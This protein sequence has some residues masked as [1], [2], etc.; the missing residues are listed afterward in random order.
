MK[1]T[2]TAHRIPH[3]AICL[4]LSAFCFL[5]LSAQQVQLKGVVTVQNSKTHTGKTQY[6]KNAEIEHVNVKNAKTKDVTGDDGKFTLNIQGVGANTQTQIAVTLHGAYS[7]Y[8]IVNE[9]ELRDITLGRLTP[10]SVFICKKGDLEQRQAEMVG[11]NMRKLEE[12]LEKDKNRLQKELNDLRAKSDYMNVRYSEIKDS[13]NVISKNI[14]NAFERIKEY[15]KSMTLENLDDRDENYVKAYGAFS[16]GELDSVSYYLRDDELDLKYQKIVQLQH[17]AKKE[18]ELAAILTE[19]AQQK[20]EYSENKLNELIKEWLLLARTYDMK[21]DYEK[22]MMYYEKVVYADTLNLDVFVEYAEYLYKIREFAKSEKYFQYCLAKY[23]ELAANNP[24]YLPDV[25]FTLNDLANLQ[26]DNKEFSVALQNFEEAL[27]MRKE[28]A[29]ENPK[30]YLKYVASTLHNLGNLHNNLNDHPEAFRHYE[31]SLKIREELAK[32]DPKAH[33]SNIAATLNNLAVLH[34]DRNELEAGMKKHQE[35]LEIRRALA[36]ENPK[37]YL[38]AVAASLNNLA[39]LHRKKGEFHEAL[40]KYEEALKI[41]KELAVENPKAYILEVSQ[42]LNNLAILHYSNKEYPAALQAFEESLEIRRALAAENPKAYLSSV[43]ATLN[44]MAILHFAIFEYSTAV[45]KYEESLII[46]EKLA[47]DNPK[48]FLPLVIA[49][50]TDVARCYLFTKK[51]TQ[52]E[53]FANKALELDS[54]FFKAT[55]NLAHALLLQNRFSEAEP[56]YLEL[57]QTIKEGNET[58]T[59]TLLN[60]L[61][62][63]EE[64]EVIPEE[65]KADVEKIREMLRGQ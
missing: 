42:T 38:P 27:R 58:Y 18:R 55:T 40:M 64:E 54:N 39:I 14:D 43:A 6:V 4:L 61:D 45:Q 30:V 25:A 16:R 24:N 44:N 28:L 53:Q 32:E 22:T 31:E 23:R 57:A 52:A 13:L 49:T 19:S 41:R 3:T 34:V 35:A 17:E 9:K 46:H 11:I 62:I 50:S 7:D 59:Q 65:R 56:L 5:P 15:A 8:V 37:A 10:I 12:R 36:A 20:E 33:L 60:D 26:R 51:F 48:V 2:H 63:L 29:V 21:N 1:K 47:I